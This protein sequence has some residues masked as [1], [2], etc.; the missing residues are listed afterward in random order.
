MLG[1]SHFFVSLSNSDIGGL[2]PAQIAPVLRK[3]LYTVRALEEIVLSMRGSVF[4]SLIL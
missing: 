1:F 3:S 4:F 2:A